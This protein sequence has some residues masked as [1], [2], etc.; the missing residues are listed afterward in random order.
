MTG[1]LSLLATALLGL[2]ISSSSVPAPT[3]V[4]P[5]ELKLELA[6]DYAP[7]RAMVR[8]CIEVLLS[9]HPSDVAE[10]KAKAAFV[11][12][13]LTGAPDVHVSVRLTFFGPVQ[14]QVEGLSIAYTYGL[15]RHAI[16]H[17]K[18]TDAD[19]EVAAIQTLI[20]VFDLLKARE[21]KLSSA[22]IEQYRSWDKEGTLPKRV[23]DALAQEAPPDKK[24]AP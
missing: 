1:L 12:K 16:D 11:M 24:T 18:G 15:A 22:A 23:A 8:A 13:W 20:A 21:P 14:E 6:E 10:H 7:H 19:H 17:P 5:A 9:N 2:S 4:V 3:C